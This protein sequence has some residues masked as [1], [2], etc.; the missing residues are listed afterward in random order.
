MKIQKYENGRKILFVYS[1]SVIFCIINMIC[2]NKNISEIL[3]TYDVPSYIHISQYGYSHEVYTAFFPLLPIL[4]KIFGTNFT[5]ILNQIFHIASLILIEKLLTCDHTKKWLILSLYAFSPMTAYSM[6]LYTESLYMFLT[7]LVFYLFTKRKIN[8]TFGII[9]GLCVMTRNTGSILFLSTFIGCCYLMYK[10][11][12]KLKT[13]IMTY[14]VAT[15]ISCIYPIY[16]Q[17]KFNNWKIF[18]DCQFEHWGRIKCNII[19][20]IKYQISILFDS[21]F[22]PNNYESTTITFFK[23]NEILT[24][25][26]GLSILFICIKTI[27]H[28]NRTNMIDSIV[29]IIYM[30]ITMICYTSTIRNPELN[31]PTVSFYRY[32][33]GSFPIYLGLQTFSKRTLQILTLIIIPIS[34]IICNLF[35]RKIFFY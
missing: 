12:L 18:I 17:M 11:Q 13:T 30:V 19:D 27:K 21:N 7:L 8:I 35:F 25:L 1:L 5:I 6:I 14:T 22:Y 29:C 26:L 24:I 4:I 16:L 20:L 33:I 2:T 10:R 3:N 23:L 15:I 9:L 31:A 32:Y 28:I 34:F